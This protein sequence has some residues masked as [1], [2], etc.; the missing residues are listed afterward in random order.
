M[1]GLAQ[2]KKAKAPDATMSLQA[3]S[4]AVGAGYSWGSG[5]LKYKG[6]AYDLEVDGLTV[7]SVGATAIQATGKVYDL[8]KLEDFDGTYTAAVG[9]GTVGGGGGGLVM[10]NQNGVKVYMTAT[11]RGASLTAGVSGVKLNIKK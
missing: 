5:K 11:T 6:K 2:A 8:K 4:I 3:K 10:E 9:G 7:G 1:P